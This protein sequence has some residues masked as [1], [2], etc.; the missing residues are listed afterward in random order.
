MTKSGKEVVSAYI[1]HIPIEGINDGWPNEIYKITKKMIYELYNYSKE[2]G[3]IL[4]D[5]PIEEFANL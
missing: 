2:M 4:E 3:Y 1:R 5:M